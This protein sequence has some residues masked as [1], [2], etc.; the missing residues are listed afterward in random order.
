MELEGI[1][2]GNCGA[3]LQVPPGV[4]FI[5][6]NH[7]HTSLAVH[8][9]ETATY[10]EKLDE[11]DARTQEMAG[12]LAQL[13]NDAELA[14]LDREWEQ[15][16]QSYLIKNNEGQLVEPTAG[17]SVVTGVLTAIFGAFWTAMTSHIGGGGFALFGVLF[18][19]I[20]VGSALYAY[21]KAN[22]L[23][24][25]RTRYQDRRRQLSAEPFAP[26]GTAFGSR[27]EAQS[28]IDDYLDKAEKR[29]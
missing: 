6:C 7:C 28:A 26:Q 15:E 13:R 8:R 21:S 12:E 5:T 22:E 16:R 24:A 9:S 20:G 25:A 11:I 1:T 23:E 14:R 3:P 19:A 29:T 2:C 10:T 27:T 4:R 18:I 17:G